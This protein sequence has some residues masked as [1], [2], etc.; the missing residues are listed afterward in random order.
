MPAR[1]GIGAGT[2]PAESRVQDLTDDDVQAI[3]TIYPPAALQC[4]V[5]SYSRAALEE[6]ACE[7]LAQ[8]RGQ[9]A[10]GCSVRSV[11]SGSS[12]GWMWGFAALGLCWVRRRYEA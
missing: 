6:E 4:G 2:G 3:C 10:S 12:S 9:D 8:A 1:L 5:A 7:Q 11:R